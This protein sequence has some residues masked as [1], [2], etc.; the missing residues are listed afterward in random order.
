[1][2]LIKS[3]NMKLSEVKKALD[4]LDSIVFQLPNGDLVPVHFHITE[5]GLITKD[6]IDCGGKVRNE[7]VV[8]FQLWEA[9]DYDHRLSPEKLKNIIELSERVFQIDPELEVEVEYQADTIGKYGISFNGTHF[10]LT[11]KMTACLAEDACGIPQ[12]KQKVLLSALSKGNTS[13][14]SPRN[15]CC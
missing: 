6:F 9:A 15:K 12:E 3:Q 13:S 4:K 5:V 10:M 1:M 11:S 8:N 14:C 7:K 2:L